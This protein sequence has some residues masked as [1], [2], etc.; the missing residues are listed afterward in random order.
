MWSDQQ[1]EKDAL[2][3]ASKDREA[4]KRVY[5]GHKDK[6]QHA[7]ISYRLGKEKISTVALTLA[8]PHPHTH[9]YPNTPQPY[10]PK[11]AHQPRSCVR[12]AGP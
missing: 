9:P 6:I 2:D 3:R 4:E 12:S 1:R 10:P 7:G 8:H 5:E 11:G